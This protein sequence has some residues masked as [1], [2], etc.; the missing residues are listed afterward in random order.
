M[1]LVLFV[2]LAFAGAIDAGTQL[3]PNS[4]VP[5]TVEVDEARTGERR[6]GALFGAWGFCRKLGMTLGAFLVSL[7]LAAVGFQQGVPPT[8]QTEDAVL[9]IRLIYAAL[10]CF[11]WLLAMAVLTR[12]DLTEE[13]FNAIKAELLTKRAASDA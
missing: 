12:F 11:L 1:A 10:P 2:L 4:M 3:M 7:A 8:A 6:E 5:D 9:G 13:R